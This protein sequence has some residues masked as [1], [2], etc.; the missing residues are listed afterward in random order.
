VNPHS[1]LSN[2]HHVINNFFDGRVLASEK[3]YHLT[4]LPPLHPAWELSSS[5]H[6]PT[7]HYTP[8]LRRRRRSIAIPSLCRGRHTR[9]FTAEG[10]TRTHPSSPP[11]DKGRSHA[12]IAAAVYPQ[13]HTH[14]RRDGARIRLHAVRPRRLDH[15]AAF[16]TAR[17]SGRLR[18]VVL[19]VAKHRQR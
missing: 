15:I 7:T 17:R 14:L 19:F 5:S 8:R 6:T 12:N 18:A 3:P 9:P 10:Q 16:D 4:P 2:P 11:P 1:L 13:P